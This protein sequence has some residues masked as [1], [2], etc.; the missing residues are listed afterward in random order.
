M[1]I[2]GPRGEED[3]APIPSKE[4]LKCP[5]CKKEWDLINDSFDDWIYYHVVYEQPHGRP[6]ESVIP[7][8]LGCVEEYK[9]MLKKWKEEWTVIIRG[10]KEVVP[11]RS[12]NASRKN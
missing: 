4:E 5:V 2:T 7:V 1:D 3:A 10:R 6:L 8:H 12:L 11:M 9:K